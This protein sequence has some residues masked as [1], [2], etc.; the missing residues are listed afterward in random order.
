MARKVLLWILGLT[1]GL[2]AGLPMVRAMFV[3]PFRVVSWS[4]SPTLLPGD[5]LL[6][7][8][9]AYGLHLPLL[10]EVL[11]WGAPERGELVAYRHPG[12]PDAIYIDR[13]L[14]LPGDIVEVR[15]N[16]V[17]VNGAGLSSEEERLVEVVDTR[18]ET[19][20]LTRYR[21]L[22]HHVLL[23]GPEGEGGRLADHGAF[24]VPADAFFLLADNRS[25]GED[26]RAFGP[27]PRENIVGRV[28]VIGF[29]FDDCTGQR[30]SER[31]FSVP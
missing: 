8:K 20:L 13:V 22:G 15:Q 23:P 17:Y 27:V 3:E 12:H 1:I 6:V 25:H 7:R 24:E 26:S 21:E 19:H 14:A 10:G 9:T 16:L 28:D 4:M 2:C 5:T 18:C 30:R 29:S 11:P 31:M